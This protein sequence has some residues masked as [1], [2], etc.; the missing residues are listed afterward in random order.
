LRVLD[1]ER[2]ES[3][4]D[5]NIEEFSI[6]SAMYGTI[7]SIHMTLLHLTENMN[8]QTSSDEV[9]TKESHILIP[10]N[11]FSSSHHSSS[12]SRN[13]S[14]ARPGISSVA[15]ESEGEKV[16]NREEGREPNIGDE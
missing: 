15:F 9:P 7:E 8:R 12:D 11:S 16:A 1:I 14:A 3:F 4:S 5:E 10:I 6:R 2:S 13:L